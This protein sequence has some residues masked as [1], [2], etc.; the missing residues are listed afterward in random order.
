MQQCIDVFK[1]TRDRCRAC[2]GLDSGCP[3]YQPNPDPRACRRT[4]KE[5]PPERLRLGIDG[6]MEIQENRFRP[7]EGGRK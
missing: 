2:N 4:T 1:I 6:N 7:L 3:E 5:G